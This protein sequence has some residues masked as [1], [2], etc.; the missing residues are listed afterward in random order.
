[1]QEIQPEQEHRRH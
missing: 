1:M